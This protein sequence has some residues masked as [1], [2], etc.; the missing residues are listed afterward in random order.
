MTKDQDNMNNLKHNY[1]F[2]FLFFFYFFLSRYFFSSYVFAES[3]GDP[4]DLK[5][6]LSMESAFLLNANNNDPQSEKKAVLI[7]PLSIESS[8][9][10]PKDFGTLNLQGT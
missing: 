3:I 1:L 7:L 4:F 2:P 8:E 5:A 6:I 9:L 10:F